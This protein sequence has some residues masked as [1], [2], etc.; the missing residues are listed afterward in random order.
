[1]QT[2][3]IFGDGSQYHDSA[4]DLDAGELSRPCA[5]RSLTPVDLRCSRGAEGG[6]LE[7]DDFF[8]K[9][10][11][12][13][14]EVIGQTVFNEILGNLLAR[15]L[16]IRTPEPVLIEIQMDFLEL[17]E[18]QGI[19]VRPGIAS[20]A[21]N[22]GRAISPPVFGRMSEEQLG[23]AS[24][25]YVFDML[26]QNPDRR[27][28]NNNCVEVDGDI[29]AIDF[30]DCF[31]FLLP[32]IG[33][34]SDPWVA[35]RVISRQH[36]FRGTIS[37]EFIEET[38]NRI[39]S[40]T[41]DRLAELTAWMPAEWMEWAARVSEHILAVRNHVDEFKWEILRSLP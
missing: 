3:V 18:S 15:A 1:M 31:S 5:L 34:A 40:L 35:D 32:I 39:D 41:E 10:V 26:V 28:E 9:A 30:G 21:R 22:L 14:P 37:D 16:G 7:T 4:D 25:I 11:G 8:V 2:E 29:V 20:G 33:G 17:L 23:Q 36:I 24:A 19:E 6:D 38:V 27:I 13:T 12:L